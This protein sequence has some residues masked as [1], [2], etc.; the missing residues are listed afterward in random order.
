MGDVLWR[1][2]E[3][4][5][6]YS[7]NKSHS[8]SYAHLAALTVYLKFNYPQEFFLSLLKYAKYEPNSHEEIAKISQELCHFDIKLLQPDLNKSDIDFKIEGKN[9]SYG[10]NSIKG[11]SDK[12][13]EALLD[14]REDSFDNKYEVFLSAKQAGLNIGTLSALIQAGLLDSLIDGSRSRLVLEAQAFNILTEREKRNFIA[15]GPKYKYDILNAV[16]ATWEEGAVG[17]DNRKMFTERRFNTWKKKFT[18]YKEIYNMNIKHIKYANWFFEE[19]LLGY[20]YSHNIR[21]VFNHEDDFHSSEIIKDLADRGRVKFVGMLTDIMRRTSRNGN[22]YA[23][24][25]LQDEVGCVNGLFLDGERDMRL[26]NY[27]DAGKKLPKKGEIVIIYGSKGDDVV[28]V[29]KVF[30]LK[31]KIYMKLSDIK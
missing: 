14:F 9:I 5:A 24:M 22:K 2:A 27:L 4:S 12:V 31:D 16:A 11:V 29:D 18:A 21:E 6:N 8:I 25:Q 19:K 15:L 26:T 17:D 10:L 20:S 3:D 1:V 28:F 7:F 13:L 30:P 23:R